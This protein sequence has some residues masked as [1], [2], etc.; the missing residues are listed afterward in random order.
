M[1]TYQ[2]TAKDKSG[3][4]VIGLLDAATELEVADALHKKEMIVVRVEV[5]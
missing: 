2:Y 3:N 1:N 5:A 4:T